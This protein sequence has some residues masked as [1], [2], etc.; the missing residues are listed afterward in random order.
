MRKNLAVSG[1]MRKSLKKSNFHPKK[2]KTPFVFYEGPSVSQMA[3]PGFHHVITRYHD[4]ISSAGYMTLNGY[5]VNRKSGW[6]TGH[7]DYR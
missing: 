4:R 3:L 2:E 7:R 6:D 1:R 5:E